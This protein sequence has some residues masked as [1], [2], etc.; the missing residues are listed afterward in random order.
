[1]S[2]PVA[3]ALPQTPNDAQRA[4]SVAH[5][6]R[7]ASAPLGEGSCRVRLPATRSC[8][9]G[10]LHEVL[11]DDNRQHQLNIAVAE[12][13]RQAIAAALDQLHL[14]AGVTA[15]VGAKEWR[16]GVLYDLRGGPDAK[17]PRLTL[18][19]ARPFDKRV[20]LCQEE[21]AATQQVL[22]FQGQVDAPADAV[23]EHHPQISLQRLYLASGGRLTEVQLGRRRSEP[24]CFSGHNKGAQV[25]EVHVNRY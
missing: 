15:S 13:P 3:E 18:S 24:A 1:V 21:A 5:A 16:K 17:H 23:E 10:F 7:A 20:G 19:S 14:D 6:S 4:L 11:V 2:P 22:T 8:V 9:K 12:S 25:T